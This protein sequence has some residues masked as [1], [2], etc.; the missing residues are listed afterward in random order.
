MVSRNQPTEIVEE[1][2]DEEQLNQINEP[3]N[4]AVINSKDIK[5]EEML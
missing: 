1:I 5:S 3:M 4:C 2:S